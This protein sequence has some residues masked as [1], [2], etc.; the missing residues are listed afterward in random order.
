MKQLRILTTVHSANPGACLFTE[1]TNKNLTT[2]LPDYDVKTLDFSP[3]KWMYFEMSRMLKFHPLNPLFN[4]KRHLMMNRF[5][6]KY[7]CL[8]KPTAIYPIGY[9]G[10]VNFIRKQNYDALVVGMVVWDIKTEQKQITNFPNIFWLSDKIEAVKIAYAT[11][12]HRSDLSLVYKH[13]PDIQRILNTYSIIGVRDHITYEIVMDSK[14]N[15]QVPVYRIP[16][17]TFLYDIQPTNAEK[18]LKANGIDLERPILGVVFYGKPEFSRQ[19]CEYYRSIGFQT[20]A[21]SMYNP[22]ADVNLGDVLDAHEWADTFRYF[23]FCVTDRFHGTVFNL[24]T[25]TPFMAIEPYIPKTIKNS[26]IFSVIQDFEMQDCYM[27]VFQPDFK[28]SEFL[29]RAEAIRLNWET[30]YKPMVTKKLAEMRQISLDFL[31][32]VKKIISQQ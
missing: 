16:D 5:Y 30:D 15:D 22:Y 2:I 13:L 32:E 9:S 14:V 26:K 29:E 1:I 19:L 18:I 17:P 6:E 12:G 25:N 7:A 28:M 27:D 11:S 8:D 3:R 23:S 20:V 4:I 31:Q 24:K 21:T 10:M